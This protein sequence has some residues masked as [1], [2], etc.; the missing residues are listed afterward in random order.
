MA[1]L[2][3]PETL[4]DIRGSPRFSSGIQCHGRNGGYGSRCGW[5]K[6]GRSDELADVRGAENLLRAMAVLPPSKITSETLSGLARLCLC[7]DHHVTAV[8]I[9]KLVK[10]WEVAVRQASSTYPSGLATP[11]A[12]PPRLQSQSSDAETLVSSQVNPF[13]AGP[14][15]VNPFVGP[16]GSFSTKEV[17]QPHHGVAD[18]VVSRGSPIEKRL[19][20]ELAAVQKQLSASRA[21]EKELLDKMHRLEQLNAEHL[22]SG[23]QREVQLAIA[24]SK[25]STLEFQNER[26]RQRERDQEIKAEKLALDAEKNLAAVQQRLSTLEVDNKGLREKE[27]ALLL[28]HS[29]WRSQTEEILAT[30]QKKCSVLDIENKDLRE[31]EQHLVSEHSTWRGQMEEILA[32]TQKKLSALNIENKDLR[33]KEQHL[34][35]EHSAWR[36]QMEETL[37]ATQKKFSALDTENKDLHGKEQRLLAEHSARTKQM[38]ESLAAGQ[39]KFAVL[40]LENKVLQEK[41]QSLISERLAEKSQMEELLAAAQQKLSAIELENKEFRKKEQHLV[42]EHLAQ[43][44]Q[45]EGLLAAAQKKSSALELEHRDLRGSEQRLQSL[46]SDLQ[47]AM[48]RATDRAKSEMGAVQHNLAQIAAE[49]VKMKKVGEEKDRQLQALQTQLD[50]LRDDNHQLNAHLQEQIAEA[51]HLRAEMSGSRI[52]RLRAW[53]KT[54]GRALRNK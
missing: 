44:N 30:A 12:T 14:S 37:A 20:E 41:E 26:S 25:I 32:A 54:K 3:N 24:Q 9:D 51:E 13:A 29:G 40:E 10:K 49:N 53:L 23:G 31:K 48:D 47:L 28:E 11:P 38:E 5:T 50:A 17:Q 2:W 15:Q 36:D 45:M 1:A 33:E 34:V 22:R 21:Q 35:S 46:A 27:Q 6:G 8:Q 16:F 52:I 42:S 7:R 43:R 4:L 39:K 18:A 19:E